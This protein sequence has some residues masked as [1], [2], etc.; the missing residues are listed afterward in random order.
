M[1]SGPKGSMSCRTQE[2]ISRRPS[3]RPSILPSFR[4]PP[5]GPLRTQTSTLRPVFCPPCPEISPVRPWYSSPGFKSTWNL[6]SRPQ[7]CPP[8]LKFD[9]RT[10]DLPSRPQI[11]P[12]DLKFALQ[13]SNLP[14]WPQICPKTSF[15]PSRPQI[16]H[17]Y[18]RTSGNSP[19]CPTGHRPFGAAALLSFH[20]FTRSLQAIRKT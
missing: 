19:L 2:G 1:G 18:L 15:Q 8:D 4:P 5:Q 16:S 3:F 17:Q 7:I 13:S 20:F 10:S 6:S 11:S 9:L 14:S 12:P